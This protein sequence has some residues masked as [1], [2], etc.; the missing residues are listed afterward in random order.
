[1]PSKS[2]ASREE[3][4][5]LWEKKAEERAKVL[6]ESGYDKDRVGADA[7]MRGL[8]A[9]IRETKARLSAIKA[10]EQKLEEMARLKIEKQE[11][12]KEEKSKKKKQEE[13]ASQVSKRQ[14]KKAKKKAEKGGG[15]Q[16][17]Q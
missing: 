16:G 1:M 4:L 2:R 10:S 5:A 12:P 7:T 13:D 8:R 6:A 15:E 17:A 3:Q 14:Q 11:A 9:K